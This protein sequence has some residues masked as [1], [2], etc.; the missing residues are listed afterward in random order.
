MAKSLHLNVTNFILIVTKCIE[1][2]DSFTKMTGQDKYV[3]CILVLDRIINEIMDIDDNDKYYLHNMVPSL[4]EIVIEASKGRLNL[5]LKHVKRNRQVN[6]SQ[7]IDD[8]YSQIKEIIEE[9][10]Y[11]AEYICTNV[12][13]IVGMLMSAVEKYPDLSGME[14]KQSLLE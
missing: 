2:V 9:D 11:S 7:I 1:R 10:N 5:N 12:V 3:T 8:L 13:V 4:I 14:K 6:V